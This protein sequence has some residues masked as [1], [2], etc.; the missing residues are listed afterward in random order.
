MHLD[1]GGMH[2][3]KHL[4]SVRQP[5]G[6]NILQGKEWRYTSE[7][8]LIYRI[9]KMLEEKILL[10]HDKNVVLHHSLASHGVFR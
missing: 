5:H 3:T 10:L 9:T 7:L 6:S 8:F 4:C 2:F 1:S